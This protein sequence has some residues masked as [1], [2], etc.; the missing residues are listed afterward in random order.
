MW[1]WVFSLIGA[2]YIHKGYNIDN[3]IMFRMLAVML[4]LQWKPLYMYSLYQ[5]T[6]QPSFMHL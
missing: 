5:G 3:S 2:C 4:A 6:K 1:S